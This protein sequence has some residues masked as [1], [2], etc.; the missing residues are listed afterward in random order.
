MFSGSSRVPY[1]TRQ[2]TF[3]LDE[4]NRTELSDLIDFKTGPDV[5]NSCCR[6]SADGDTAA[7]VKTVKTE[8]RTSCGPMLGLTGA[9]PPGQIQTPD[10]RRIF[11][12]KL[13]DPRTEVIVFKTHAQSSPPASRTRK[14]VSG[15][16]SWREP[17]RQAG[18]RPDGLHSKSIE[19]HQLKH[20]SVKTGL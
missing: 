9:E 6:V 10:F 20:Q 17:R 16:E 14:T 7:S 1:P 19:G 4:P 2:W 13:S 12:K 15:E 5:P 11:W 18:S 3:L 8:K